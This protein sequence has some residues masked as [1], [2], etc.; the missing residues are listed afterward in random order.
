[1]RI[2]TEH[3]KA[4]LIKPVRVFELF[5]A[6]VEGLVVLVLALY[7]QIVPLPLAIQTEAG[8]FTSQSARCV[9]LQDHGED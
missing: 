6:G 7:R 3:T 5:D 9:Y 1:M 2:T 4:D 8:S